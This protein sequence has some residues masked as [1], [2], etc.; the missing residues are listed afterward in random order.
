MEKVRDILRTISTQI[1]VGTVVCVLI[2][3]GAGVWAWLS[4]LDGLKIF[5]IVIGVLVASVVLVNQLDG[6][7]QRRKKPLFKQSS[8]QIDST[9]R[10]W[11]YRGSFTLKKNTQ[12]GFE[13]A[14]EAR[15]KQG[16]PIFVGKTDDRDEIVLQTA[17]ILDP[18]E[19]EKVE[20][21]DAEVK[22]KL[23]SELRIS[24]ARHQVQ[25][26]GLE[27]PMSKIGIVNIMVLD[28]SFTR[29]VFMDRIDRVRYALVLVKELLSPVLERE[30]EE[31]TPPIMKMDG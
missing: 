9:L 29:D 20:K 30:V 31:E 1:I 6:F 25:Y 12:K 13:F 26:F 4:R 7:V 3:V 5:L 16:R 23:I 24:L 21:L 14:F 17:L 15:D 8:R 10:D 2:T 28:E 19:S 11:L 22:R 27:T 18:N